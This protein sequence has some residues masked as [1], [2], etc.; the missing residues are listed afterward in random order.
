MATT[1]QAT[2]QLRREREAQGL[3]LRELAHFANCSHMT[4]QRLEIGT[5]DVAPATRARIA[6]ALRVPVAELWPQE[7]NEAAGSNGDLVKTAGDDSL[8]S[9]YTA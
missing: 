3:S 5:L 2:S 8:D 4:V 1:S 6:H 7:K 9:L